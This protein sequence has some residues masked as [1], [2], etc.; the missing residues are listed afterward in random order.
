MGLEG[1]LCI[2]NGIGG[3]YSITRDSGNFLLWD[4]D[5]E[6][7]F[8]NYPTLEEAKAAG[9]ADWQKSVSA[10]ILQNETV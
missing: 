6:F 8:Q 5:D 2:A 1:A 7:T 10:V 4:A 3:K 9:E